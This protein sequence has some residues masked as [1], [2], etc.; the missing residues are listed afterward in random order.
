MA[1]ILKSIDLILMISL[2]IFFMLKLIREIK[3]K[4]RPS[5]ILILW[6]ISLYF[7][8]KVLSIMWGFVYGP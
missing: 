8:V 2:A 1:I 4:K 3:H 7:V 6:I 5:L